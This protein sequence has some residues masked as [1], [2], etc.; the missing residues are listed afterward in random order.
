MS[1]RS[2]RA[3]RTA[4]V[5][6]GCF[7]WAMVVVG[8]SFAMVERGDPR[9][10]VL[11]IFGTVVLLIAVLAVRSLPAPTV[12]PAA[13]PPVSSTPPPPAPPFSRATSSR[14]ASSPTPSSPGLSSPTPSSPG[15]SSLAVCEPLSPREMDVLRQLAAGRS[16][17]EIAGILFV[18]PGTVKAHLSHIFRKLG[19]TSRLQAVANARQA[20]LLEPPPTAG[21]P[22]TA[23]PG[24]SDAGPTGRPER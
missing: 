15:L 20:G 24:A 5:L 18:A 3:L 8:W 7:T 11:P 17:R 21:R 2:R 9:W 19:A 4:V 22:A 16:N 10:W 13:L 12:V 14:T 6:T 23:P 1:D